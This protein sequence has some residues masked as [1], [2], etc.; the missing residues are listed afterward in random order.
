MIGWYSVGD[1]DFASGWYI[2]DEL[3]T[4]W[5]DPAYERLFVAARSTMDTGERIK[6]YH[7]VMEILHQQN[8]SIFLFGLLSLYGVAKTISGFGAAADKL[9]RLT[10][11]M[12]A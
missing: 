6:D 3:R 12:I 4:W 2:Q 8:P 7:R 9:L 5:S 11:A 10:K 1:A